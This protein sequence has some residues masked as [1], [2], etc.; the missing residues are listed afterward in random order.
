MRKTPYTIDE[1]FTELSSVLKE[2][3]SLDTL[4]YFLGSRETHALTTYEFQILSRLEYG[5]SEGIY[6]NLMI[7]IGDFIYPFGTCKTLYDNN[8]AM[9]RMGQLYAEFVLASSEFVSKNE[10]DFIYEGY[11]LKGYKG[12][13]SLP[14]TY[15]VKTSAAKE[16]SLNKLFE[17]EGCDSVIVTNYE[18]R[19]TETVFPEIKAST[20][21]DISDPDG[22]HHCPYADSYTGF[23]DEMCRNCCGLGVD[24]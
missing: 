20:P 12:C 16:Q 2:K 23:E 11:S 6:L 18:R 5:G 22:Q 9:L 24:E 15:E 19:E 8:E 3:G 13:D 21:C 17:K 14:Y 1:Y 4:D 10:E 7:K